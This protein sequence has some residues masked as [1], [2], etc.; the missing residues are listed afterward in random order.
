MTDSRPARAA[1]S[2]ASRS[3]RGTNS[4]EH[5]ATGQ[6]VR[7]GDCT[8]PS[9]QTIAGASLGTG[10]LDKP[11]TLAPDRSLA[12]NTGGVARQGREKMR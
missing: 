3:G 2:P 4:P 8:C 12:T 1:L 5:G 7:T 10:I 11:A 6:Q 9:Q